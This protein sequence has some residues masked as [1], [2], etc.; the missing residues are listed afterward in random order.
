[1]YRVREQLVI[2]S[3]LT[4]MGCASY[5][6]SAPP[7]AALP[8]TDEI[9]HYYEYPAGPTRVATRTVEYH[10][11]YTVTEVALTEPGETE[12]IRLTWYAPVAPGLHPLILVSPIRGSNTLV[13]DGCARIFANQGWHAA[14]VK[15]LRD[16]FN[17][18]GPV[19]QVEDYLRTAVIRQRQ[20]LDW[21]LTRPG[22]D[23]N[24]VGS[25]GISYG[26]IINAMLA[27]VEPR[28]KVSVIDLA[29][30]PLPGVMKTSDERS[31]R[32]DWDRSRHSHDL[33]NKEFY[34]ALQEVVRTDPVKLAPYVDR[35]SVLMLIAR[36]DRSVPT[37]YQ[38]KLWRA[39]GK[40]KADFVP[41]G[42]Y[43]SILALPAHRET[44]MN[45]F[46]AHFAQEAADLRGQ[47]RAEN[48]SPTLQPQ[49]HTD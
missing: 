23:A 42:H 5:R 22:V 14:I 43:T 11:S 19:S 6:P 8:L 40:P 26:A 34:H 18:E 17:P 3:L 24:R 28:I 48:G 47:V 37:Q 13:V 45:F 38:L 49:M 27:A 21:L 20:A 4:A 29:G 25:F 36:F 9:R 32:R 35:D 33:T 39:L 46:S 1:M 10:P 2:A 31:L 12:R 30:G 16:K 41:L 15:R 44:L 7:R